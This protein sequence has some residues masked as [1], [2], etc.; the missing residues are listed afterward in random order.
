MRR[1]RD[2][3]NTMQPSMHAGGGEKERGHTCPAQS[4]VC[5]WG[6]GCCCVAL[7]WG[8]ETESHRAQASLKLTHS[9]GC[10]CMSDSPVSLHLASDEITGT[11]M[12]PCLV[13]FNTGTARASVHD[14]QAGTPSRELHP[15]PRTEF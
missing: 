15:Q 12:Q 1:H 2:D 5:C 9:G 13:L 7:F 14:R 6:G 10:P 3:V 8:N 11:S 4:L